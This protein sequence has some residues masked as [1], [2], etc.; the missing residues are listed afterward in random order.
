MAKSKFYAVVIGRKTGVFSSWSEV[1]ES[2]KG[3]KGAIFK[4]DFKTEEDAQ[5]YIDSYNSNSKEQDLTGVH[6][7][8]YGYFNDDTNTVGFAGIFVKDGEYL[9]ELFGGGGLKYSKSIEGEACAVLS[10]LIDLKNMGYD[11]ITI[12]YN[13][14]GIGKWVTSEWKASSEIAKLYLEEYLKLSEDMN[15]NFVKALSS[16]EYSSKV[17]QL[18]KQGC[19]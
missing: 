18:A 10:S 12:H 5:L 11:T 4:G 13:Y 19:K 6:V 14:D 2:I 9:N 8:T 17:K 7:W 15:C 1:E 3:F 16:D